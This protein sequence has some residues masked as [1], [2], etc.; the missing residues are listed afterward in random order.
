MVLAGGLFLQ[1]QIIAFVGCLLFLFL[2][3]GMS[4]NENSAKEDVEDILD[5]G[6]SCSLG[7]GLMACC[8][9]IFVF[10]WNGRIFD[11]RFYAFCFAAFVLWRL[12]VFENSKKDS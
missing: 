12:I 11:G 3:L 9:A 7:C 2:G 1:G 8:I 6:A 10:L 4:K 5:A